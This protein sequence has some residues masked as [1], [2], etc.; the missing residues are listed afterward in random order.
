MP[1]YR[2]RTTDSLL[3]V[4]VNLSEGNPGAVTVMA[5]ALAQGEAIDPDSVFGG[6]GA[7]RALDGLQIYGSH[8]WLLFKDLCR[9]KPCP[10]AFAS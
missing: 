10:A 6:M 5:K 4:I 3:D 7:I 8:I 1:D 9:S 2:I